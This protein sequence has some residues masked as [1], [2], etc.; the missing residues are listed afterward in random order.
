VLASADE[1]VALDAARLVA[2]AGMARVALEEREGRALAEASPDA[3]AALAL[4][5]EIVAA[6]K[7]WYLEAVLSA[8]RLIVGAPREGF[9]EDLAEL[10]APFGG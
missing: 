2:A 5:V 9:D 10:A 7:T 1:D 8:S 4:E 6:W 3:E